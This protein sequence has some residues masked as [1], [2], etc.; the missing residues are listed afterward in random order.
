VL[1]PSRGTAWLI[2]LAGAIVFLVLATANA[3]GYRYGVGDQAFYIPAIIQHLEPALFPRD[4]SLIGPQARLTVSD[5]LFAAAVRLTGLSL[6]TLFFVGYLVSM[7]LLYAVL[8]ALSGTLFASR[9]TSAALVIACTLRH[10][11]T[12]TGANTLEGYFHPRVLTF[13]IGAFALYAVLR[14]RALIAWL[15]VAIAF[16]VHPTTAVY[17]AVWVW[18]ALFVNEPRQRR[19]L[20]L[21]AA[22]GVIGGVV[23][24]VRGTVS[25]APMDAAWT[26][27]LVD[28]DYVFP[29]DWTFETWAI[30]M[31]S[32][33]VI[34]IAFLL[35][36][37]M[38]I[39]RPAETGL[40]F[41]CLSLVVL[42]LASWPLLLMRSTFVV[43][44]QISR[45][46]WLADLLATMYV[47][48]LVVEMS[49][50][51][52]QIVVIVL[53][54]LA[55]ARGWYTLDFEHNNRSL[56]EITLPADEWT[57]IG[58]FIQT[59]SPTNSY[60]LS[61][62]GHAWRYGTSL[63]VS[64][65][66]DVFIEDIKDVAIGMYDR[67]AA[68]A[69]A[70]R[71]AALGDWGAITVER[72]RALAAR[73]DLEYLVTDQPMPFTEMYHNARFHL[74]RLQVAPRR[75]LRDAGSGTREHATP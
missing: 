44:F 2:W 25:L 49:R 70:E 6:P 52:P 19:L 64:A 55:A 45:M 73:Y 3:A 75:A 38:A 51:R 18:V 13:A 43:Q 16:V 11:I 31:L 57:D 15:L 33:I 46:F 58:R 56:F 1:V 71:R 34:A 42:F 7:A 30:N 72:L 74:Y 4:M 48:W 5:E 68:M 47:V 50:L 12:K 22:M 67:R 24:L 37:R 66:R 36:R 69:V 21:M 54:V 28:K 14:R 8:M 65:E 53:L 17:F 9:W 39:L 63:R 62:P 35:R 41:G 27:T 20:S 61:D 40:V 23:L 60:L 59:H 10:R 29:T 26:A 32:P